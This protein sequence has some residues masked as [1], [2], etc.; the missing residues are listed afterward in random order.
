MIGTIKK[1][2]MAL[3]GVL[4]LSR[5]GQAGPQFP[6]VAESWNAAYDTVDMTSTWSVFGINR[7]GHNHFFLPK[8]SKSPCRSDGL[9]LWS[10]TSAIFSTSPSLRTVIEGTERASLS[11][12]L[13]R[14]VTFFGTSTCQS[15]K[16]E[17][18][19]LLA[20]VPKIASW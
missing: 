15:A 17:D 3:A 16:P 18:R 5:A 10:C 20:A 8:A 9:T 1:T 19:S 6:Y 11:P 7:A 14:P 4:C 12:L 2:C 13:S